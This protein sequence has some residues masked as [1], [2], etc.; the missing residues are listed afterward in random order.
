MT[1]TTDRAIIIQVSC[2][3]LQQAYEFHEVV[4]ITAKGYDFIPQ[5][6][7]LGQFYIS[8]NTELDFADNLQAIRDQIRQN[9]HHAYVILKFAAQCPTAKIVIGKAQWQILQDLNASLLLEIW[10]SPNLFYDAKPL[11][12]D[13]Q[14]EDLYVPD[15][16]YVSLRVASLDFDPHEISEELGVLPSSSF[17]RDEN[18]SFGKWS[19]STRKSFIGNPS[20][21]GAYITHLVDLTNLNP[22]HTKRW[23]LAGHNHIFFFFWSA[24]GQVSRTFIQKQTISQLLSLQIDV[25]ID[26]YI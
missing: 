20:D 8:E 2:L 10:Q 6:R 23:S 18:H 11:L 16:V 14:V 3:V 26:C 12:L 1:L 15:Q 13:S 4:A 17:K 19:L 24:K 5:F 21:L 25:V 7:D 22:S 9:D